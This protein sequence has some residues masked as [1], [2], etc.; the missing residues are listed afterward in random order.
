MLSIYNSLTGAEAAVL[1]A[2]TT[3]GGRTYDDANK[4]TVI[5]PATTTLTL[6]Q[7]LH[8][9]KVLLI[10]STGGLAVT[11]P[12]AT[13]TGAEYRFVFTATRSLVLMA[14]HVFII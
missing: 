10:A 4:L 3:I 7:A 9:G 2:G 6:T 13:G 11:P 14:S 12:A 1:K 8:S 5:A